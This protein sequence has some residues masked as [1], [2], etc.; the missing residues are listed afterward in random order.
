M[1]IAYLH[2]GAG[3]KLQLDDSMVDE[4]ET[5]VQA[6]LPGP[7]FVA[8]E[9]AGRGSLNVLVSASIPLMI[10]RGEGATPFMSRG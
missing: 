6:A 1:A 2:Y 5:A 8:V 4:F 7:N 10:E 9:L 3:Q